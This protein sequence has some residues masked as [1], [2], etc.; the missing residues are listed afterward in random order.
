VKQFTHPA[1]IGNLYAARLPAVPA[2]SVPLEGAVPRTSL[3]S[4]SVPRVELDQRSGE[5][6]LRLEQVERLL[7]PPVRGRRP[8]FLRLVLSSQPRH[9][10]LADADLLSCRGLPPGSSYLF[11]HAL[12]QDVATP[13]CYA[14]AARNCM[15]ASRLS[16]RKISQTWLSTSRSCSLII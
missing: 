1:G 12:V 2:W 10:R 13:P 14:P 16:C 6:S 9:M 4:H 8:P 7:K 3:W 5:A 15:A 11:K